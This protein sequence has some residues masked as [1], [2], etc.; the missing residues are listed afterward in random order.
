MVERIVKKWTARAV[1]ILVMVI[2]ASALFG[3]IVMTLWNWLMPMLFGWHTIT[4]WQALGLFLLSKLLFGGFRGG[5]GHG[6][7][8]RRG[9]RERWEQMTP[10]Q[11]EQMRE[12]LRTRCGH[13]A[14]TAEPKT[15]QS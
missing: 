2:L 8:W 5:A 10:E 13:F 14:G 6:R 3:F 9:M 1:K 7:R 12:R 11:Q 4:F 15:G